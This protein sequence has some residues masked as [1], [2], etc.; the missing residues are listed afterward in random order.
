VSGDHAQAAPH[1]WSVPPL[2]GLSS[3]RF[4][5]VARLAGLNLSTVFAVAGG[6]IECGGSCL[7][8][9]RVREAARAVAC[10]ARS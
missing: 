7:P 2:E 3:D 5:I 8:V 1:P 9:D 10:G 6:H 4:W